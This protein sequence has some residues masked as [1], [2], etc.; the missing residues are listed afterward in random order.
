[1]Q[2]VGVDSGLVH[3]RDQIVASSFAWLLDDGQNQ[4]R[5]VQGV[6]EGS[7]NSGESPS[8]VAGAK[9][10]AGLSDTVRDELA[11]RA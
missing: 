5:S 1:M 10:G 3:E 11:L 7:L 6:S 4:L 8:I 9:A 2:K